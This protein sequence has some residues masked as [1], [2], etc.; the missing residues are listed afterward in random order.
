M[1][2]K[3]QMEHEI[4]KVIHAAVKEMRIERN[5]KTN[6]IVKE[7]S[8]SNTSNMRRSGPKNLW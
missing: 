6:I 5:S 4:D 8:N 3:R 1:N 7:E 2:C